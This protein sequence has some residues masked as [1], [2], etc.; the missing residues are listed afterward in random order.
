MTA[1]IPPLRG[2]IK[3]RPEDFL[4]EEQPLYQPC[5][6][7]EHIYLFIE[8]KGLST[9]QAV[10]ALARHFGVRHDAIG[11]AGMKDKNAITRQVVS[12]HTP[13]K[14][15]ADFPMIQNDRLGVLWADMHTN[16]LRLGHLK[17]NRFSIRIRG[18]ALTDILPA[19]EVLRRLESMGVPNF[20]GEQRFGSRLNNH[21]LGRALLLRDWKGLLDELLGPDPAFPHLN[22]EARRLYA[23]ADYS[24]AL[25]AFP[26]ACRHERIALHALETGRSPEHAVH[27]VDIAQRRFWFSSWQSWVFNVCLASRL[28]E[29][30][31]AR[32]VE[33]DLAMK[34]DNGA[35]FA[36]DAKTLTDPDLAG[37]IGRFEISPT[38]PM[39]GSRMM[40]AAGRVDE[41]ERAALEASA[42]TMGALDEAVRRLGPSMAGARRAYR[43]PLRDPD[44]EAGADEHGPFIRCAFELPPG[45]FATIVLR[46]ILKSD[47]GAN[48]PDDSGARFP[49]SFYP[50]P[51]T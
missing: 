3:E 14:T 35:L 24:R 28:S 41:E 39:W 33:G 17:G 6:S 13:K 4:V 10:H 51:R 9:M 26:P 45:A 5:G 29:G 8:K 12:I 16:K 30:A 18:V 19:R 23:A 50:E 37:R 27:A 49:D 11:Y 34:L 1:D 38:G 43:V 20:A 25:D 44:I 31:F 2:R 21:R 7:G 36:V 48:D 46:E 42:V 15:F 22:A 32:L 40:R 47:A